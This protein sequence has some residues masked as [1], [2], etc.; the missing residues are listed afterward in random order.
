MAMVYENG[1]ATDRYNLVDK[2]RIF[3]LANG[4]TINGWS[5]VTGGGLHVQKGAGN[6]YD[7]YFSSQS[8]SQDERLWLQL[9]LSTSYLAP[10][11]SAQPGETHASSTNRCS[12]N[13]G[14]SLYQEYYF[15]LDA[16]TDT[17]YCV[18]EEELGVYRHFGFGK[19]NTIGQ[20]AVTGGGCF[21]W[22]SYTD[23]LSTV[24]AGS[25]NSFPANSW[26]GTVNAPT[27]TGCA[28]FERGSGREV[29]FNGNYGSMGDRF[30][31]DNMVEDGA[32]GL[33]WSSDGTQDVPWWLSVNKF[34]NRMSVLPLGIWVTRPSSLYTLAGQYPSV[35]LVNLKNV[36][37]EQIID[38]DWMCFPVFRKGTVGDYAT[39][40]VGL[41]YKKV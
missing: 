10:V 25:R 24:A 33:S 31:G 11:G 15:F 28:S 21:V 1:T 22:G 8:T 12:V 13:F 32:F 19:Y 20:S 36:A 18:V 29:L 26:A 9:G 34:N 37:P 39:G 4:W 35:R 27:Y 16:S 40:N 14:L 6:Y 3:L 17:F 38:G 7:I 23:Y 41:A 5:G 2:I 30:I